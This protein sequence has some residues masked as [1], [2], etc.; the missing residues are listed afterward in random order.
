MMVATSTAVRSMST[1]SA[2]RA[3]TSWQ[4][5]GHV[6]PGEAHLHD[7]AAGAVRRVDDHRHAAVDA[8]GGAQGLEGSLG[9]AVGDLGGLGEAVHDGVADLV[10]R[11]GADRVV[12]AVADHLEPRLVEQARRASCRRGRNRAESGSARRSSVRSATAAA[13]LM[14]TRFEATPIRRLALCPER[15][16]PVH[17]GRPSVGRAVHVLG[18]RA[19]VQL[20]AG[21]ERVGLGHHAAEPRLGHQVVGAVHP[22]D[23]AGEQVA[24]LLLELAD[25]AHEGLGVVGHE[26]AVAVALRQVLGA[27]G[28]A[29]GRLH[30]KPLRSMAEGTPRHTT[31]CSKPNRR[32]SW[33]IWATWPNMSGR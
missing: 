31:A 13:C 28:G 32:R 26:G 18:Q 27:H 12:G 11:A 3:D 20:V 10:D 23:R 7:A 16:S 9:E 1:R 14:S 30:Q 25:A 15:S 22:E 21:V 6:A 24:L 5:V 8:D 17:D 4:P 2:G 29:V 33:G 19:D